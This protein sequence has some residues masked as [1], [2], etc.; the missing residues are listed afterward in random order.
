VNPYPFKEKMIEHSL[1]IGVWHTKKWNGIKVE[2][3]DLEN[4]SAQ[5][6]SRDIYDLFLVAERNFKS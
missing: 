4:K 5:K 6:I 2:W 1:G 3:K